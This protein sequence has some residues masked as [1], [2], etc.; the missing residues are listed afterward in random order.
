LQFFFRVNPG[1]PPTFVDRFAT[2]GR[3]SFEAAFAPRA[4]RYGRSTRIVIAL[5]IGFGLGSL[6]AVK[7]PGVFL[8]ARGL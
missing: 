4:R 8:D 5:L 7:L 3:H 6:A 2:P 1:L